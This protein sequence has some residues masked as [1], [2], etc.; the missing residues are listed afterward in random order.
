MI[1]TYQEFV[2][3]YFVFDGQLAN[4]EN[5]NRSAD[6]LKKELMEVIINLGSLANS[7]QVLDENDAISVNGKVITI[8]KGDGSKETISLDILDTVMPRISSVDNRIPKFDGNNGSLSLTALSIDDIDNLVVPGSITSN[9]GVLV[10][11]S[12]SATKLQTPRTINL[13]GGLTGS[14]LFDGSSNVSLNAIITNNSH[15]HTSSNIT[16]ATELNIANTIIKRDAN[17]NFSAGNITGNLIGNSTSSNTSL[18]TTGNAG[19]ATK[20]QTARTI[21]LG[22]ALTGSA[23]FDGTS[24]ITINATHAAD[25]VITLT[26]GVTGSAVMYDLGNVSISTTITND[27]HLHDTR[28]Y[29]QSIADARFVNASGDGTISGQIYPSTDSTIDLGHASFKWRN[30][31]GVATSANYADLAEKYLTDKEYEVGTVLEFGGE[32]EL[33]LFNGGTLAGAISEKPGFIL[34]EESTGQLVALKGKT[35][36]KCNSI[37]KRGQY[38]VAI[39]NGI[40]KGYN[41]KD[42]TFDLTLD[43][44]GIALEDSKDNLVMVKI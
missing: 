36:V 39:G 21:S 31:Y 9:S 19:S 22:G 3:N 34:N 13:I 24:N 29:T 11:N 12:S 23:S 1:T 41:K 7:K 42:M 10:G 20:L 17:G 30:I 6:Q 8:K 28:Y 33:T 38:C 44:V 18:V 16:D 25:P 35:P 2:E 26:G 5:V 4:A 37:I 43:L 14:V 27:S 15:N 40:V 32:K